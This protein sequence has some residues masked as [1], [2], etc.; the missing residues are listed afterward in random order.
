[1]D[2]SYR[3]FFYD[4]V[5]RTVFNDCNGYTKNPYRRFK[6]SNLFIMAAMS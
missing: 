1:M 4:I 6:K 2:C 5:V 3:D